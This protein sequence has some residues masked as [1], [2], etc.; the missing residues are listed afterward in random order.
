M[1]KL[2]SLV[3]GFLGGVYISQNYKIPC[4]RTEFYKI[5]EELDKKKK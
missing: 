4:I 3:M 2:L 1:S 5:V